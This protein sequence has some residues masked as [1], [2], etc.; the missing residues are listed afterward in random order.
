MGI[1]IENSVLN[2]AE[3]IWGNLIIP[4]TVTSI[5]ELAYSYCNNLT[6]ITMNKGV[7]RI[8]DLAFYGC[9][10]LSSV[11]LSEDLE[12][13]GDF[14]FSSCTA[15]TSINLPKNL[16][17]IGDYAFENCTSLDEVLLPDA[18]KSLGQGAFMG[19]G[20]LSKIYLGEKLD[21]I[22]ESVFFKCIWL[23]RINISKNNPSFSI[24]DG[25]LY[26][27]LTKTLICFPP[28]LEINYYSVL[29]GTLAIASGAFSYCLYLKTIDIP[30]SVGYI[31]ANV[32]ENC[33][34][35]FKISVSK[36]NPSFS[37]VNGVLYNNLTKT[38]ICF[39]PQ[40]EINYYRVLEGTLVIASGAFTSCLYL[41]GVY[42]STGLKEIEIFAFKNNHKL[43]VVF[44]PVELLTKLNLNYVGL[45]HLVMINNALIRVEDI[46]NRD[47]VTLLD[48]KKAHSQA[49]DYPFDDDG[50]WSN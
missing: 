50:Y 6:S 14:S 45:G 4:D 7:K 32:F 5:G 29:E 44:L 24:V 8:D 27:D 1:I 19:C 33:S 41:K 31:G 46:L 28:Q 15:L 43:A 22:G 16:K 23:E 34:L 10:N 48:D 40:L 39:P 25:V 11:T 37:I 9:S 21:I 12:Y 36:D 18:L 3:D 42:I 26:N 35:L 2:K 13:I 17:E 38:L 20:S 30:K 47:R 49:N